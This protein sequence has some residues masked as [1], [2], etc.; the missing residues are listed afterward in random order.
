MTH[1]SFNSYNEIKFLTIF[2]DSEVAKQFSLGKTKFR[3]II[4]Y[5]V[6]PYAKKNY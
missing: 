5:G 2:C 3:Y 1:S 6:A 4:N